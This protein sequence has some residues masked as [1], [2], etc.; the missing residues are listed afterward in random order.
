MAL[1]GAFLTLLKEEL[2]ALVG[3]RVDKIHQPYRDQ[4][5]FQLRDKNGTYRLLF[6]A[7]ADSARLHLTDEN[8][9]NPAAPPMFCMLLRKLLTGARLKAL[10]QTGMERALFMDFDSYNELGDPI[11]ITLGVEIM[12]RHS[13]V[14]LIGQDGRI[15]DSLKRV[16]ESM[17]EARQILPGMLYQ[18][19]PPQDKLCALTA[20]V[21]EA[22]ERIAAQ[23]EPM[24]KAL[25]RVI[26]GLS[27][28]ICREIVWQAF[29]SR[30]LT[31]GGM[32]DADKTALTGVL[33]T[34]FTLLKSGN[35][36]PCGVYSEGASVEFS[37][38]PL[39]QYTHDELR[40]Y[41]SLSLLLDDFYAKKEHGDHQKQRSSDLMKVANGLTE[42][43]RRRVANQQKELEDT[44]KGEISRLY[45]D[46]I[47]ANL[48]QMAKG[49]TLLETVNFYDENGASVQIG[50]DARLTPSQNAQ[51]YYKEYRKSQTA[52]R[53]LTEQIAAGQEELIY[54]ESVQYALGQ[55]DSF[56]AIL[57]IR[58]ELSEQGYLRREKQP[59]GKQP[60]KKADD[61][62]L[63]FLSSDGFEIIVGRNNR[64]NDQITFK[65][66]MGRDI[67]F[68]AR[69]IPGS[70]T[71]LVTDGK[72][73][74]D[75]SLTEAALLAAWYSK[76]Q[77]SAQIPV[78]YTEARRVKKPQGAKPGFVNYF[79]F[80]TA[81][82]SPSEEDVKRLEQHQ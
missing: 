44:A 45:G 4:L 54:L 2:S 12:G 18:P 76:A 74:P 64:Q 50:L 42:R 78:D 22:M 57:A 5:I 6:S 48:H 53:M 55:A 62:Y 75:T 38:M 39:T 63:R 40:H 49:D 21:S 24:D 69:N 27:P 47:S 60:K 10:R 8:F 51:R 66:A 70:H 32:T 23:D 14:V 71:L 65:K 26:Q 3:V 80:K 61:R 11:V 41:D 72:T 35:P 13:N 52:R 81:F 36:L 28:T 20:T 59:K 68:H 15:I 37:Y 17:S 34:L 1:D 31:S 25:L 16:D 82:V 67:W 30:Y 33:D 7:K 43:V 73:P 56:E 19:V 79:E 29:G 58:F 9:E 77:G 46:L